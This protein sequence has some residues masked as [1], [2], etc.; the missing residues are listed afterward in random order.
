MSQINQ[1]FFF[2]IVVLLHLMWQM[3]TFSVKH[4]KKYEIINN[5]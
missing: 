3:Y 1:F 2:T 4:P 5:N